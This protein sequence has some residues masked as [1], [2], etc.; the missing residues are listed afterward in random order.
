MNGIYLL[1]GSNLGDRLNHLR[2]AQKL[3]AENGIRTL[4]ESSVYETEP[5]GKHD[6]SWFLNVVLQVE[7]LL[8]PEDLLKQN[9]TIEMGMGRKREEKWG[10]RLIDI[11]ILYYDDQTISSESLTV[12][13]PA[14]Q[15]RRFTL[16][17]MVELRPGAKHPVSQL[18]QSE[19]LAECVDQLVC[20]LT[21]LRL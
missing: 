6:Q 19:L 7:T 5:W 18:T 20:K 9:L 17:P 8:S 21:E 14:I 11:D 4:N 16:I 1:L 2:T 10:T 15:D 3:L 12:P 13:H